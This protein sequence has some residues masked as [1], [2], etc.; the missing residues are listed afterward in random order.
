[1]KHDKVI[2]KIKKCLALAQSSNANEAAAAM[3]QAQ[4]LMNKY[5]I[6]QDQVD[7]ADVNTATGKANNVK[8]PARY[9]GMLVN[10][11]QRAFGVDAVYSTVAVMGQTTASVEFIGIGSQPEIAAYA[12]DVLRRQLNRDRQ[13]Y[14]KTLKRYKPANKTRKADAFA[15]GWVFSVYEKVHV[16]TRP[17]QHTQLIEKFKAKT[18]GG[19]LEDGEAR[20]N[21][22]RREDDT[23]WLKGAAAG[24]KAN[25]HHATKADQRAAIEQQ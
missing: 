3:R 5:G 8:K 23:A 12:Y 25:L 13:A 2:D 20:R 19:T 1:M 21:K 9:S 6:N 15:E 22:Y 10:L 14:L 24:E 7:L 17:E 16:F 18:Y 4:A 11:I